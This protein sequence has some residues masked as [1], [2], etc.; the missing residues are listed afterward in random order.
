[1]KIL[2]TGATGCLGRNLVR[3]LCGN[4]HNVRA[5]GRDLD[6]GEHLTRM[7]ATFCPAKLENLFEVT[8]LCESID[9]V[10]HCAALSSPWGKYEDFYQSNVIGTQNIVEGCLINK[11]KK[12]VH[13]STPSLYFNFRDQYD[14]HE[15]DQLPDKFANAYATTKH[16]AEKIID[17]ASLK[18]GLPVI[19]L[20]PRGIFGPYDAAIFPRLIR[21][22]QKGYIPLIDGGKALIDITYV[23]NV[24][25]SIICSL[26]SSQEHH[27]KKYNITNG[28]PL[29]IKDLLKKTFDALE[30]P[31]HFKNMSYRHAYSIAKILEW[32][33]KLPLMRHEPRLTQ[34]GVG[35]LG[36]SQ[37]L[38]IDAA[39][40]DLGYNPIV[41]ID[42]GIERYAKWWR[43]KNN[44]A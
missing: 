19:T 23:D 3:R 8:E 22:A 24:V 25:E 1:M 42:E 26:Y 32:I 30:F 11:V 40:R 29:H 38:N 20:R 9:W 7:K 33:A 44:E 15:S 12:L 21:F 27:G 41:S 2:V 36:K 14:I 34:Y 31:V 16:L 43:E 18:N 39:K 37:T 6:I 10:I 17:E 5:T 28:E 13:I 35:V 4:G